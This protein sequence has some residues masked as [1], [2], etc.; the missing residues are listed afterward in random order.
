MK[1]LLLIPIILFIISCKQERLTE[2]P[3]QTFH[4]NHEIFEDNRL[5]PRASF[6][7]F[8]ND[9]LSEKENS[10]RFLSLNGNWKFHWVKNPNE[11]PKDFHHINY[12]DSDWNSIKVPGNWETQGFGKPIYLDERYPFTTKWPNVP[13]DYNPVGTYRKIINLDKS[14]LSQDIILHFE[15]IKAVYIYINGEYVGYSQGSKTSAEFDI[16][17][18]L[19][20]GKNLIAL[21]MYRWTDAS[22]LES[23]DMLRMSGIE[24]EVYLYTRSKVFIKDIY[25]N[26]NLSDDYK[27]G[28]FKGQISINN[29]S[30]ELVKKDVTLELIDDNQS[31]FKTNQT[32]ELIPESI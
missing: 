8:E 4:Y 21:Q 31:L 26:T 29:T 19:N 13:Q 24:R 27:N 7:A 5:E 16:T 30:S 32:I 10:K 11:R 9:T 2:V 25:A 6:F 14:F 18:Y 12:D 20:E 1:K 3:E 17:E 28:I 22:Y 23:Q 15:A